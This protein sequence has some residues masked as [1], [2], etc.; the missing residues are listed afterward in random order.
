[1]RSHGIPVI[2]PLAFSGDA[3]L[4]V[5]A[6]VDVVAYLGAYFVRLRFMS[7]LAKRDDAD[8]STEPMQELSCASPPRPTPRRGAAWRS[9]S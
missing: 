7:R 1:M 3:R 8:A 2:L 4:S 5:A 6:G 9:G